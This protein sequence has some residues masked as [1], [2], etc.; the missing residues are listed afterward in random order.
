MIEMTKSFIKKIS[1]LLSSND[2]SDIEEGFKLIS[3]Y[4][5]LP[6][7][8]KALMRFEP[9]FCLNYG[10]IDVLEGEKELNCFNQEIA[11]LPEEIGKLLNLEKIS[12][13]GNNLGTLPKNIGKLINLEELNLFDNKISYLPNEIIQLRELKELNLG[14]NELEE[15]PKNIGD[16]TNLEYLDL[17]ENNLK[18][19]PDSIKKLGK[20]RDLF[21]WG[22]PLSESYKNELT[23]LLPKTDISF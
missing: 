16:L 4:R 12:L 19:L 21:L 17:E 22:N 10:F 1:S 7:N 5:I 3:E 23:K 6:E 15:L 13:R 20:L 2:V 8:V 9:I 14:C 18:T 11:I